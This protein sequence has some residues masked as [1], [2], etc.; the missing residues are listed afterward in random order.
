M[1]IYCNEKPEY[2]NKSMNSIWFDQSLK[3]DQIVLVVDGPIGKELDNEIDYW[4][5][6]LVDILTIVSLDKNVGLGKALNEGLHFCKNELVARMDTDDL[7][8]PDRF[9]TQSTFLKN[10]PDV[11]LVGSWVSEFDDDERLITGIRKVPESHAEILSFA[12]KRSPVNH[13]SVMFRKSLVIN[14]G[15]YLPMPWLED[16][17]LWGRMLNLGMIF[18]NHPL[19]L[20]KMRAG[21]GQLIRRSGIKYSVSEFKLLKTFLAIGF[22]SKKQFLVSLFLRVFVRVL[23]KKVIAI[24][25]KATRK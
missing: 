10:H 3:P 9:F 19:P 22:I 2:F 13:P 1:S 23:P 14:A 12:K 4:K 15:G 6:I 16:Y 7:S 8:M 24:I 18:Y 20:V 25:Y 17:F 5:S 11:A 21:R